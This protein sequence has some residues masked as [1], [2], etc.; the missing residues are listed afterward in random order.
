MQHAVL[1]QSLKGCDLG[2][3]N[4]RNGLDARTDRFTFNNDRAGATLAESAPE[5]RT[6]E[7]EIVAQDIQQRSGWIDVYRVRLAVDLQSN[8]AHRLH[9]SL[10][11]IF[12]PY[13]N[14]AVSLQIQCNVRL[15]A[16]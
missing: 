8:V 5:V 9:V 7:I 1:G 4:G 12:A 6:V 11:L 13:I 10:H 14:D 3:L 15:Q 2:A 16:R